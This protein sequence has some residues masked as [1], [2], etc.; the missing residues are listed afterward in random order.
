MN[1]LNMSWS[2]LSYCILTNSYFLW[3]E[4]S[5]FEGSTIYEV[6]VVMSELVS[7]WFEA[8]LVIFF[9]LLM[10]IEMTK[11]LTQEIN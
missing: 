1:N 9:C 5:S 11:S 4:Q 6:Q 8:T 7:F 3:I 10:Q 2:P